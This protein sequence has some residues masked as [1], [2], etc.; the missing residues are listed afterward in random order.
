V[1]EALKLV[2]GTKVENEPYTGV[3]PLPSVRLSWKTTDAQLL[4]LAVSRAVRAPSRIDRDLFEIVGPVTFLR[5]GDFQPERLTAYEL[6]YRA[7]PSPSAAISISTFYN[8][9]TDLRSLET[10]ARTI[11]PVMFANDMAGHTY[12]AE[13]WGNYR[14]TDWWHL[15]A[16]A[17]WLHESLHFQPGSSQV[18]GTALAGDDPTYQASVGSTIDLTR[19]WLLNVNLRR[20]GAL[21]NPASPAYTEADARISWDVSRWAEISLTGSN[22]LH[23]HHLEFG[24]AGTPLQL[25]STG[26]ESGRSIFLQGRLRL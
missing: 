8:V 6:G 5:G 13:V 25:G 2:L 19:E 1:T 23:A 18:G 15:T 14:L 22:L 3:E 4:W 11:Y 9:Y 7:Q 12:G 10:T 20:I 21:P 16:G 17:N 26:V 24:T